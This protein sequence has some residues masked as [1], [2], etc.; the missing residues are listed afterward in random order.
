MRN[1]GINVKS[2]RWV[3]VKYTETEEKGFSGSDMN[4][5]AVAGGEGTV[6]QAGM[7]RVRGGF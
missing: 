2:K 7:E 4:N 5:D 6:S 3:R 1:N